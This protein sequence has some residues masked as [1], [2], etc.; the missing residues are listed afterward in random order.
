MYRGGGGFLLVLALVGWVFGSGAAIVLFFI[1]RLAVACG[2]SLASSGIC[3]LH[4]QAGHRADKIVENGKLPQ[5]SPRRAGR[6][7]G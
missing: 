1:Q 2:R 3:P 7:T 5:A 4:A 6:A